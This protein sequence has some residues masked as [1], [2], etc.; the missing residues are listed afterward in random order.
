MQSIEDL[1]RDSSS[2]QLKTVRPEA[3]TLALSRDTHPSPASAHVT[4]WGVC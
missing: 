1:K 2:T 3:G 4:P